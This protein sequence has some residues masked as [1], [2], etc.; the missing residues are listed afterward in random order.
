MTKQ[1]YDSP[2]DILGKEL[3]DALPQELIEAVKPLQQT[4]F[5]AFNR[6]MRQ[7]AR[8]AKG[9]TALLEESHLSP[10]AEANLEAA[11]EKLSLRIGKQVSKDEYRLA[12]VT[13]VNDVYGSPLDA[14][15]MLE[16]ALENNIDPMFAVTQYW[17]ESK[18]G[19]AG[20][21]AVGRT[22]N[23]GNVGNTGSAVKT[24]HDAY[25]GMQAHAHLL[26]KSY[27]WKNP[28][29]MFSIEEATKTRMKNYRGNDY[30]TAEKYVPMLNQVSKNQHRMMGRIISAIQKD[31]DS[32]LAI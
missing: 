26:N 5:P 7:I 28:E 32:I 22:N 3:K 24:F 10:E 21:G 6:T 29:G 9:L 14:N 2:L 27:N 17:T 1:T 30:A 20:V 25:E 31:D 18:L 11:A 8:G 23:L 12:F 19:R 15:R 4:L 13:L 16:I